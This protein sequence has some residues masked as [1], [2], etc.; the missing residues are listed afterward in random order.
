MKHTHIIS[1]VGLILIAFG[2]IILLPIVEALIEKEY[3]SIIPFV[4]ASVVSLGAGVACR[5][6]GGSLTSFDDIKRN[7]GMLIVCLAWTTA[8]AVSAIPY[9]FYGLSPLDAYFE[10]MSGITTT[11]ATILLDFSQYPKCFFFWR[12]L[13][14]WLGGMGIIVLFVAI[15]PQFK[16]AGRQLFFAEAPGPT[17]EKVT[18]RITQTAKALWLIYIF[19]T[20]AE[21]LLLTAAGM[22]PFDAVCNSFTTM[23]A[24]GFS[25][26]PQSIMGYENNRATWIIIVFMLLAG[27]SFALQ[28]RS[29]IRRK[30]LL[31]FKSEEFRTYLLIILAAAG[32]LSITLM[33]HKGWLLADAVRDSLFQVI[34]ILTTTGFA[35]VD[36][37]LWIVPAQVVLFSVMLIGGCAGSAGGGIKV[38]RILFGVKYLRGEIIKI[39]YPSAV[40]PT[41]IDRRTVQDSIQQQILGFLLF[42]LLILIVSSLLVTGIEGDGVVGLVGTAV[43]IGNIGPGF[44]EIGPM[45]SFGTLSPATKAIFILNMVLGRL[46]LIP[47]LAMLHPDFWKSV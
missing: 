1:A 4:C 40:I 10:S 22:P 31:L 20:L 15:L 12:S 36:F 34:S 16:I 39:I 38:V 30:P 41:K 43:T 13:T 7:E 11:G 37:A 46:E 28:Y 25:P 29:V 27:A 23:S 42:Y 44:G 8:A 3:F 18:P 45:A 5:R 26:N 19:L 35:T 9:R 21:I 32:I 14:Q 47:F 24:G 2:V 6:A 17:E 33:V